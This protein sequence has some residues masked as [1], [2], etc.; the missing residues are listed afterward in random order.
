LDKNPSMK[1]WS[2]IFII[3]LIVWLIIID[4]CIFN[5]LDVKL[6]IFFLFFT[7]V[8]NRNWSSYLYNFKIFNWLQFI[9]FL[10]FH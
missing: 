10:N 5:S 3:F 9:F 4:N 1:P 8:K 2:S 7:S 6:F